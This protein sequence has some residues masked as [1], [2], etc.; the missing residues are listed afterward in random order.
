MAAEPKTSDFRVIIA[1]GGIAGL[2]LAN[3]LQHAGIDYLLLE[4]RTEIAPQVGA[5]IGVLP[6]GGRILDQ[7]GCYEDIWEATTPL[8]WTGDHY[9]SGD[10]ILPESEDIQMQMS[11]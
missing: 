10:F 3:A 5:S 4:G 2:T 9:E 7:L 8:M 11:R 6:N 1:G